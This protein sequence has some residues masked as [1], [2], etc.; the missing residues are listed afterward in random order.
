MRVARAA[1]LKRDAKKKQKQMIAPKANNQ[2]KKRS[3]AAE[4]SY[5]CV[6][7]AAVPAAVMV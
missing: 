6:E 2:K 1:L 7:T 3:G 5:S 4:L